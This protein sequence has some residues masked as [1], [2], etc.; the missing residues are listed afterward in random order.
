MEHLHD[1][2][3]AQLGQSLKRLQKRGLSSYDQD[4]YTSFLYD[5]NGDEIDAYSLAWRYL[6]AYYDC[7]WQEEDEEG[8]DDGSHDSGE[9]R[10][11]NSGDGDD[12][13]R[14]VLWAAVS[15]QVFLGAK[16]I[17]RQDI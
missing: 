3:T 17:H 16:P 12:C 10:R 1:I 14:K 13:S 15:L 9:G 6:G 4:S 11:M 2:K 8:E 7:D 5:D